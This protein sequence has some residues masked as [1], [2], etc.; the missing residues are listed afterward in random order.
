MN[1][2]F[3]Y[4]GS[5]ITMNVCLSVLAVTRIIAQKNKIPFDEA[6]LIFSKSKTCSLL[7]ECENGLW[8]ESPEYIVDLFYE[9][10]RKTA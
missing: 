10:K 8:T 2:I 5:D 1:E 9:E 3:T 4:N 6:S 7:H